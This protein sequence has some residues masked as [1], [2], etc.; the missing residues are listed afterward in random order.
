MES[1]FWMSCGRLLGY[2]NSSGGFLDGF[3][4]HGDSSRNSKSPTPQTNELTPKVS[5]RASMCGC[6]EKCLIK[7]KGTSRWRPMGLWM[8][9]EL[10]RSGWYLHS[11]QQRF[12]SH[13]PRFSQTVT[14]AP[15]LRAASWYPH[16]RG[17]YQARN[18]ECQIGLPSI[19][20]L[21]KLC[22]QI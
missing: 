13:V 11:N 4:T 2:S 9:L 10:Q 19:A 22:V 6:H 14:S 7:N 8:Y 15:F 20:V 1:A 5:F 18:R 12:G 3:P 16:T 17:S 21:K